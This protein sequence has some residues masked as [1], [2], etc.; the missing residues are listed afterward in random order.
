MYPKKLLPSIEKVV[1]TEHIYPIQNCYSDRIF[2]LQCTTRPSLFDPTS[3]AQRPFSRAARRLH[4]LKVRLEYKHPFT[5]ERNF[6]YHFNPIAQS[7]TIKHP[8]NLSQGWALG[9]NGFVILPICGKDKI[10]RYDLPLYQCNQ[11]L[12]GL[13]QL[14]H[15]FISHLLCPFLFDLAQT[16]TRCLI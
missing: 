11:V 2:L 3:A 1:P 15:S 16:L 6:D 7:A 4:R 14:S 9:L 5:G 10:L 8:L 13:F 12:Q